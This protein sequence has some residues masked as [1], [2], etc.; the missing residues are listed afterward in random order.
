VRLTHVLPKL[1]A[2]L[3]LAASVAAVSSPALAERT[4]KA[5]A[6]TA[7]APPALSARA[8]AALVLRADRV[9]ELPRTLDAADKKTLAA[10][11][12]LLRADRHDA[13]R[14]ALGRWAKQ[15][16]ARLTQDDTIFAALWVA[17]EGVVARRPELVDAADRVRFADERASALAMTIAELKAGASQKGESFIDVPVA[18]SYAKLASA[19]EMRVE[20]VARDEIG[21]R[22]E[23]AEADYAAAV[24]ASDDQ[25]AQFAALERK[26][27]AAMEA[28]LAIVHA[29]MHAAAPPVPA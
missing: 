29:A 4:A 7:A 17:R 20:R 15:A 19:N 9:R 12:A 13:A 21:A 18:L 2:A 26:H 22:L 10:A 25:H 3:C 1:T 23:K 27:R 5:K 16:S 6:K 28:V 14:A 11:A 24:A 8:D